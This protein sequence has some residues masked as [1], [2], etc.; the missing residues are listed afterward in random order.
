[1]DKFLGKFKYSIA[2][3]VNGRIDELVS[4]VLCTD[5]HHFSVLYLNLNGIN[6]CS[7]Y[8]N[9]LHFENLIP[10]PCIHDTPV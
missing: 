9:N 2:D 10:T 6:N 4:Q 1:M 3:D 7:T 8:Y 5:L